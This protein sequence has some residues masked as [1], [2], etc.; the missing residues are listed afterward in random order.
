L[1]TDVKLTRQPTARAHFEQMQRLLKAREFRPGDAR[2]FVGETHT[3]IRAG[4][5]GRERHFGVAQPPDL[6]CRAGPGGFDVPTGASEEVELPGGIEADLEYVER[7]TGQAQGRNTGG[8]GTAAIAGLQK[9]EATGRYFIGAQPGALG[10]AA[11]TDRR[12][13]WSAGDNL[14]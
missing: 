9:T 5:F 10:C 4:N 14:L 8:G 6:R 1:L 3:E 2:A 13:K 12:P 11:G 7:V